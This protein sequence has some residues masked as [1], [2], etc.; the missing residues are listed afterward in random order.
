MSKTDPIPIKSLGEFWF[1][2]ISKDGHYCG[3]NDIRK[4]LSQYVFGT[5]ISGRQHTVSRW[6]MNVIDPDLRN[7]ANAS[8]AD[9]RAQFD[10]IHGK[11]TIRSGTRAITPSEG[12][13]QDYGTYK[14]IVAVRVFHGG[15]STS[16]Q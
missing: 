1:E 12:L 7:Q 2:H 8:Q 11:A 14:P 15:R 6:A 9:L 10:K 5:M 4:A 3:H 16:C 13:L